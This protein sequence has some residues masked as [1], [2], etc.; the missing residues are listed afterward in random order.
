MAAP[1]GAYKTKSLITRNKENTADVQHLCA[2][3]QVDK[4]TM[5]K[6]FYL[7]GMFDT[8]LGPDS[9]GVVGYCR[10]GSANFN[11]HPPSSLGPLRIYDS[12]DCQFMNDAGLNTFGM[13]ILLSIQANAVNFLEFTVAILQPWYGT[14]PSCEIEVWSGSL[15]MATKVLDLNKPIPNYAF[16][17]LLDQFSP[18][19]DLSKVKAYSIFL[20][21]EISDRALTSL[22]YELRY[23]IG[24]ERGYTSYVKIEQFALKQP[25]T[26][27]HVAERSTGTCS[28]VG[29][30]GTNLFAIMARMKLN[31]GQPEPD[32]IVFREAN[33][34]WVWCMQSVGSYSTLFYSDAN[35]TKPAAG[36]FFG[37]WG[38]YLVELWEGHLGQMTD[39]TPPPVLSPRD[40]RR[41]SVGL[42]ANPTIVGSFVVVNFHVQRELREGGDPGQ[43]TV[44]VQVDDGIALTSQ[45]VTMAANSTS[46]Q[47]T[48]R[49]R[50]KNPDYNGV[51]VTITGLIWPS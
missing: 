36:Y 7:D 6:R 29:Q 10:I 5:L 26:V 37:P 35:L 1:A 49:H 28:T 47:G 24:D 18:A 9:E 41:Y 11:M 8:N 48:I 27:F 23:K 17:T 21:P 15:L 33:G 51:E 19:A 45:D 12:G 32:L 46:V 42:N 34:V 31:P 30:T 3:L 43:V 22:N 2:I 38:D 14:V 39:C 44:T 20:S 25:V 40:I 16:G 50:L 4:A 13:P